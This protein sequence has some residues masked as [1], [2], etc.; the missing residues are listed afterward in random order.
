MRKKDMKGKKE[1]RI[2][3]KK[4]YSVHTR[5]KKLQRCK[6]KVGTGGKSNKETFSSKGGRNLRGEGK[7]E[8][9][10]GKKRG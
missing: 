1:R 6:R 9:G 7:G 2:Q 5:R 8:S 3:T 10:K 4:L